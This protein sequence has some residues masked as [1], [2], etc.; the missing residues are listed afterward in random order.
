[1]SAIVTC[2]RCGTRGYGL[3][4]YEGHAREFHDGAKR[5]R[6]LDFDEVTALGF[7]GTGRDGDP[8]F[9]YHLEDVQSVPYLR[10]IL[11]PGCSTCDRHVS[12]AMMPSHFASARCESGGHPHC[13]CDSCF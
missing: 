11:V 10:G 2:N 5:T 12:G 4:W 3:L 7:D 9:P 13:T 6:E 8:R 1:M